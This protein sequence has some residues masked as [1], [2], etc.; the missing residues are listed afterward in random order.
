MFGHPEPHAHQRAQIDDRRKHHAL[1]RELLN[2]MQ[3]GF[4][5]GAVPLQ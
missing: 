2:A 4:P 5:L 1:H 3:Q